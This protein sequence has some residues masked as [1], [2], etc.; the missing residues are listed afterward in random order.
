MFVLLLI[1]KN[2]MKLKLNSIDKDFANIDVELQIF[3]NKKTMV[4]VRAT[5]ISA[6]ILSNHTIREMQMIIDLLN[7]GAIIEFA[8]EMFKA[9]KILN[10]IKVIN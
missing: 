2:I 9:N 3:E 1:K 10:T 4:V 6:L 7:N 8:K 5:H